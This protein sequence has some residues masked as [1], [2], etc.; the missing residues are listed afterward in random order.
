MSMFRVSHDLEERGQKL[1]FS[2]FI[3]TCICEVS[4]R[5]RIIYLSIFKVKM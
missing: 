4:F 5:H 1:N 2:M 3:G